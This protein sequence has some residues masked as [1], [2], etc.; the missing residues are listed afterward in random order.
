M[1]LPNEC[2]DGG[3]QRKVVRFGAKYF[4]RYGQKEAVAGANDGVDFE[5]GNVCGFGGLGVLYGIDDGRLHNEW[6]RFGNMALP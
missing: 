6:E 1:I 4:F 3:A 2:G 5:T